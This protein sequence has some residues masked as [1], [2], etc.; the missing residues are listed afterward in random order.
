M[1]KKVF[2]SLF[3]FQVMFLFSD[4]I[5]DFPIYINQSENKILIFGALNN[6]NGYYWLDSGASVSVVR[7]PLNAVPI[8]GEDVT[9]NMFGQ[10]FQLDIHQLNSIY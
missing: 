3:Y 1:K 8:V 10:Q 5:V 7:G 2:P 6:I 4:Q 9:V